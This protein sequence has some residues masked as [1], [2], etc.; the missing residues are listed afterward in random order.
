MDA[1][2]TS[3]DCARVAKLVETLANKHFGDEARI[4][5]AEVKAEA[6]PDPEFGS[7]LWIRV[8][9]DTP[10]GAHLNVDAK[11]L[12]N[13]ELYDKLVE[14]GIVAYPILTFS[15]YSQIGDAA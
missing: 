13:R 7:Q 4:V 10:G 14:L 1:M 5:R 6:D 9:V 12:F 2:P 15:L 8:V 11:I 3:E